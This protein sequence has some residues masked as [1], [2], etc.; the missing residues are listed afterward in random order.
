LLAETF[1]P[2]RSTA[3]QRKKIGES[4]KTDLRRGK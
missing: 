1:R 3:E 4:G 2:G